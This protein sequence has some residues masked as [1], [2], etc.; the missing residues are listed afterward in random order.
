MI[1]MMASPGCR[2]GH[3]FLSHTLFTKLIRAPG[4]PAVKLKPSPRPPSL[5]AKATGTSSPPLTPPS[6]LVAPGDDR[7]LGLEA[8]L[9]WK[10]LRWRWCGLPLGLEGVR[11]REVCGLKRWGWALRGPPGEELGLLGDWG[12]GSRDPGNVHVDRSLSEDLE[13]PWRRG[14]GGAERE[15]LLWFR[16]MEALVEEGSQTSEPVLGFLFSRLWV[17]RRYLWEPMAD[18]TSLSLWLA[19]VGSSACSRARA[20]G[21]R[22]W[23]AGE[24]EK[25][26]V[27]LSRL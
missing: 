19:R 10:P 21:E 9:A 11:R 2:E 1:L 23:W 20:L 24:A 13:A 4:P 15:L 18:T 3:C 12:S 16:I 26:A 6:A 22:G 8:G 25:A 14:W 5:W 27:M 17:R 7:L